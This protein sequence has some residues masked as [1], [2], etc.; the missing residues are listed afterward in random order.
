MAAFFPDPSDVGSVSSR[1]LHPPEFGISPVYFIFCRDASYSRLSRQGTLV[2]LANLL[3]GRLSS[4]P[5]RSLS[6][7]SFPVRTACRAHVPERS[8]VCSQLF[9]TR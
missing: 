1:N 2:D 6:L 7:S 5:P 4:F 8:Q 3:V 9:A